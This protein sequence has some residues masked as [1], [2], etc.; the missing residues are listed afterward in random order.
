MATDAAEDAPGEGAKKKKG[1]VMPL[2]IGAAAALGLGAAA[3][4]AV[5]TGV[6]P[7]PSLGDPAPA[8]VEKDEPSL[9]FVELTPIVIALDPTEGRARNLRLALSVETDVER[10]GD[11]EFALPRIVDSLNT[12]L[13]AIDQDDLAD[14]TALDRLRAQ[15]RRRVQLATDPDTVRDLLIVEYVIF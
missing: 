11:V 8:K 5:K 13:R 6:V 1:G 4:F 12:L 9:A 15:M 3:A 7:T 14:P 2:I 10:V